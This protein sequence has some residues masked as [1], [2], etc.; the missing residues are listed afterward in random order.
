[1]KNYRKIWNHVENIT[2]NK[3]IFRDDIFSQKH[4][5]QWNAI[6]LRSV[7]GIATGKDSVRHYKTKIKTLNYENTSILDQCT[8]FKEILNMIK[9]KTGCNIYAV[10]L[11]KLGPGGFVD[12]HCDAGFRDLHNKYHLLRFHIPIKTNSKISMQVDKKEYYL[13]S[14][15]IHYLNASQTHAVYNRS[16]KDRVH[17]VIDTDITD[18]MLFWLWNHRYIKMGQP[19]K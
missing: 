10:R 9:E 4:T 7:D 13:E 6:G 8:Y 14:G 16:D 19:D 5:D 3:Y 2:N 15:Y 1:M 18:R 17:L 12:P 11:L